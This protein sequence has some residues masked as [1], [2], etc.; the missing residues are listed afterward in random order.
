[1]RSRT[2]FPTRSGRSTGVGAPRGLCSSPVPNFR[3]FSAELSARGPV[4]DEPDVSSATHFAISFAASVDRDC[5]NRDGEHKSK[6]GEVQRASSRGKTPR[7][8]EL[9]A[10]RLL[11]KPRLR[12]T[13]ANAPRS[14][15]RSTV[16]TASCEESGRPVRRAIRYGRMNSPAR[17][18]KAIPVNPTSVGGMSLLNRG[19]RPHWLQK[20]LPADRSQGVAEVDQ[21]KTVKDAGFVDASGLSPKRG[22]VEAL[23]MTILQVK[24]SGQNEEHC[25]TGQNAFFIHERET[26]AAT[27]APRGR[28]TLSR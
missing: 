15:I 13:G 27:L 24:Q 7:A 11:G 9:R 25:N 2:T 22:P 26:R 19:L 10:C 18:S 20:N 23:P 14:K 1:M 28:R 5:R 4:A 6:S 17:P 21:S 12:A 3:T 16:H 8:Q